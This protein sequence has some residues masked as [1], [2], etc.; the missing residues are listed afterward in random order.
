MFEKA[1][2]ETIW[3]KFKDSQ[4]SVSKVQEEIDRLFL[5]QTGFSNG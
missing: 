5:V 4:V 2:I 3:E 1:D